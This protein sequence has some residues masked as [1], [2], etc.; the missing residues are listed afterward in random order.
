MHPDWIPVGTTGHAAPSRLFHTGIVSVFRW[1]PDKSMPLLWLHQP[2]GKPNAWT[3]WDPF[4]KSLEGH[5]HLNTMLS[6]LDA[7]SR[8]YMTRSAVKFK[9]LKWIWIPTPDNPPVGFEDAFAYQKGE[10]VVWISPK[11]MPFPWFHHKGQ[12]RQ[13]D[14]KC[15]F[16]EDV[17]LWIEAQGQNL[18]EAM[19]S[20]TKGYYLEGRFAG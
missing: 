7:C 13:M 15:F 2:E 12:K 20:D 17:L 8:T 1:A 16:T 9:D 18:R 3:F 5:A 19:N 11:L 4:V 10:D 6:V 14:M